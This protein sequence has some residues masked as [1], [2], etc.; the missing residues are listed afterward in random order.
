[1][2]NIEKYAN[3]FISVFDVDRGALN[4]SFNFKDVE[5]WNSIMHITLVNELEAAFDVMFE[6]ED[7]LHF[8]GYKNGI[9]I[10]KK[11]GVEF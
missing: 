11:Y 5:E 6:T 7:I 8:G 3:V 9:E 4:E 1:M 10:L 2:S